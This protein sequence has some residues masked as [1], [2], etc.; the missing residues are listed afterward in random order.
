MHHVLLYSDSCLYW[1]LVYIHEGTFDLC[2]YVAVTS[3]YPHD[4]GIT[5]DLFVIYYC[6]F[7][8]LF[9]LPWNSSLGGLLDV[10][11]NLEEKLEFPSYLDLVLVPHWI[12]DG[13]LSNISSN[14][15]HAYCYECWA[16]GYIPT[17]AR[18]PNRTGPG[19]GRVARAHNQRT[20]TQ[21]DSGGS[22]TWNFFLILSI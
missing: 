6:W 4:R 9:Y 13:R 21:F 19:R 17:C 5:D 15:S 18:A 3:P 22:W 2:I 11:W 14:S 7:V 10:F 12:G 16:L 1:C 20:R 8:D